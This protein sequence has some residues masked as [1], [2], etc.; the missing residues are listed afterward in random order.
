MKKNYTDSLVFDDHLGCFGEFQIEDR[1]CK[2]YCALN[3]RCAIE[4][5]QNSQLEIMEEV[6]Y[7]GVIMKIQ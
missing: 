4:Y 6:A 2:K 3:L 7:D 5:D 1:V